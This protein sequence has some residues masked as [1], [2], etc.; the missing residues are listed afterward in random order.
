MRIREIPN[1]ELSLHAKPSRQSM[2]AR[3]L[4][5]VHFCRHRAHRHHAETDRLTDNRYRAGAQASELR[6]FWMRKGPA[7]ND[8][9]AG[10]SAPSLR[11]SSAGRSVKEAASIA[12]CSD[13]GSCERRNCSQ[14]ARSCRAVASGRPRP[15]PRPSS[16]VRYAPCAYAAQADSLPACTTVWQ[17]EAQAMASRTV[18]ELRAALP[19]A[20]PGP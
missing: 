19:V 13:G 15:R 6:T 9:A 17:N 10:S 12:S 1:D 4:E 14:A 20:P 18:S 2:T 11:P 16:S 3:Q 7:P 8:G 5:L